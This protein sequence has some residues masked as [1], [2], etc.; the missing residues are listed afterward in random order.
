MYVGNQH[1]VTASLAQKVDFKCEHCGFEGT[2]NV[3]GVG[4]GK[5]NSAY[6][7]DENGAKQRAS[8]GAEKAALKNIAQTVKIAKCPKCHKR[9]SVNVTNFWFIQMLKIVGGFLAILLMGAVLFSVTRDD[10][11]FIIFG[12]CG[13]AYMPL[14]FFLDVK[15]RWFTVDG[16][17]DFGLEDPKYRDIIKQVLGDDVK[18]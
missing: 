13:L 4:Q 18:F 16:R 7:M 5:G 11:I 6:F 14:I 12:A 1:T 10:V 15:W 2:P 9:N 8:S 3:T 17:V